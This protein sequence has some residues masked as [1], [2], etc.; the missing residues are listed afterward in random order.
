MP[1][2]PQNPIEDD[3]FT[4][5]LLAA[6][7]RH[8]AA[9]RNA[10]LRAQRAQAEDSTGTSS[11]HAPT[12]GSPY[13]RLRRDLRAV[14]ERN[15]AHYARLDADS[16]SALTPAAPAA[17][18]EVRPPSRRAL[19]PHRATMPRWWPSVPRAFHHLSPRLAATLFAT[20]LGA[21]TSV[22]AYDLY[23]AGIR[24]RPA[25]VTYT[26][27]PL[28]DVITELRRRSGVDIRYCNVAP[29]R[30]RVTLTLADTPID[31]VLRQIG[32]QNK[33]LVHWWW[34][35]N[36]V[37]LQPRIEINEEHGWEYNLRI[38]ALSFTTIGC[39]P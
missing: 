3:A 21:G 16:A 12:A 9:E 14:R 7:E 25:T 10:Q 32:R 15:A 31:S 29:D 36:T 30:D 39:R 6:L 24:A 37:L 1:N 27:A 20:L 28:A 23:A 8:W 13:L 17:P 35:P 4:A 33:L 38:Y 22:Y 34:N 18:A 26:N 2:D 11:T 5:T 19:P